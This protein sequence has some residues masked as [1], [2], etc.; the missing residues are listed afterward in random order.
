MDLLFERLSPELRS[1]AIRKVGQFLATTSLPSMTAE[2]SVL[3]QAAAYSDAEAAA[4]HIV[5]PVLGQIEAELPGLLHLPSG[6]LSK[7]RLLVSLERICCESFFHTVSHGALPC[8]V[9]MPLLMSYPHWVPPS[10]VG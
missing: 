7:V 1:F 3:A 8:N 5:E 2:A 9:L 10:P 4:Q 6:Q